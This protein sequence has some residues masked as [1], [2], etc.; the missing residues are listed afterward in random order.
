MAMKHYLDAAT[1]RQRTALVMPQW[2]PPEAAIADVTTT[3]RTNLTDVDVYVEP[4]R[5]CLVVDACPVAAEA[6]TGL[7]RERE[8]SGLRPYV[9]V[10]NEQ[11]LGQ[12]GSLVRGFEELRRRG[13]EAEWFVTRDA[14]GDHFLNDL[15]HLARMAHQLEALAEDGCFMVIGRRTNVRRPMT[16]LRGQLEQLINR[17]TLSAL[18]YRLARRGEVIDRRFFHPDGDWPDTQSGYKLYARDL[19]D[20]VIEEYGRL[21]E[22]PWGA[23]TFRYLGQVLPFWVCIDAGGVAGEVIRASLVDQTVS[24]FGPETF[25]RQY[26]AKLHYVLKRSEVTGSVARGILAGA[27]LRSG[28]WIH[29][30]GQALCRWLWSDLADEIGLGPD[31]ALVDRLFS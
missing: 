25:R 6:A 15:P 19:V 1:I 10:T 5:V 21:G 20:R 29:P 16:W 11:N 12:G 18:S 27:M 8:S 13:G 24:S 2:F 3:M 23:D 9:V 31:D 30:D 26:R 14:D 22:P 7:N 28:L 17:V 4:D